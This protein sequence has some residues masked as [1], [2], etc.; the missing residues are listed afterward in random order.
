MEAERVAS[1]CLFNPH[2]ITFTQLYIVY[3]ACTVYTQ[4]SVHNL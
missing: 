4:F 1:V 3:H 2:G